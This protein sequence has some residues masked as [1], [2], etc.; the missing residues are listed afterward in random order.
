MF[1]GH[2]KA[3]VFVLCSS[4][5][6]I[7]HQ[8][9]ETDWISSLTELHHLYRPVFLRCWQRQR[10]GAANGLRE[11]KIKRANRPEH[12]GQDCVRVWGRRG[13][14]VLLL[15]DVLQPRAT[16][17]SRDE[18]CVWSL[19]C[20]PLS[21]FLLFLHLR[22]SPSPGSLSSFFY[23]LLSCNH[24]EI[25]PAL[26]HSIIFQVKLQPSSLHLF[27]GLTT[28]C[29]VRSILPW[30]PIHALISDPSL[31][32]TSVSCKTTELVYRLPPSLLSLSPLLSLLVLFIMFFSLSRCGWGSSWQ[33]SRY[34]A[35][36]LTYQGNA[37]CDGQQQQCLQWP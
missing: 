31:S 13:S 35:T 32:P 34:S 8:L 17:E 26:L 30:R 4:C 33:H 24:S 7:Q 9:P 16:D 19:P 3:S 25:S 21:H 11:R 36:W 20:H 27:A 10:E 37:P 23:L 12:T 5:W 2:V 29:V 14:H 18:T 15:T 22:L 28:F 6:I 1:S